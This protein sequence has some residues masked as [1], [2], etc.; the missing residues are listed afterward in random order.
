MAIKPSYISH[1]ILIIRELMAAHFKSTYKNSILI[2]LWPILAPFSFSL[3][4]YAVFSTVFLRVMP[5]PTN[6]YLLFLLVGIVLWNYFETTTV[7]VIHLIK[8]VPQ[9]VQNVPFPKISLVAAHCICNFLE[10][11]V[12]L[13]V[14]FFIAHFLLNKTI[15]IKVLPLLIAIA[16]GLVFA[17]GISLL[18]ASWG[19]FFTDLNRVWRVFVKLGFFATPVIYHESLVPS[20]FI[21]AYKINPMYYIIQLARNS[22]LIG[23]PANSRA[24]IIVCLFALFV[25]VAGYLVF[26]R[27]EPYFAERL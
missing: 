7:E 16:L 10:L 23:S 9:W 3:I 15:S 1:S 22:F 5:F 19:I 17:G 12:N 25:F 4:L 11:L 13:I 21:W 8:K 2:F 6:N 14:L 26:K 24:I 20:K 27:L 18:L